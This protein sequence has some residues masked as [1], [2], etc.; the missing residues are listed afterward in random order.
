MTK[1]DCPP[2]VVLN[3][4]TTTGVGAVSGS[5]FD[6]PFIQGFQDAAPCKGQPITDPLIVDIDAAQFIADNCQGTPAQREFVCCDYDIPFLPY[7]SI[8]QYF[9]P[10]LSFYN[11][12]NVTPTTVEYDED[13]PFPAAPGTT[14]YFAIP[15]DI[16]FCYYTFHITIQDSIVTSAAVSSQESCP[17]YTDGSIDL[18]VFGGTSPFTYSW[19]GPSGFTPATQDISSL[20]L[21]LYNVLITDDI[22][23]TFCAN[24]TVS[25]IPD[26]T[27]PT[28]SCAGTQVVSSDLGSCSYSHSGAAWDVT[29]SDN[30]G[31]DN[32]SYT[33]IDAQ[34]FY[35]IVMSSLLEIG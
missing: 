11:E 32:F 14:T 6:L 3:G 22:G 29:L 34:I 25:T 4:G 10:G 21:G 15:D 24:A 18:S 13:N 17:G 7:D 23:C 33:L 26:T 16:N 28:V 35:R 9:P 2:Q 1:P 31:I 20:E 5:N 27:P 8:A 30:C 19:N 12:N